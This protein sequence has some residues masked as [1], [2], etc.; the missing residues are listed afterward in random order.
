[1][2]SIDKVPPIPEDYLK[3]EFGAIRRCFVNEAYNFNIINL[4]E[5]ENAFIEWMSDPE[6]FILKGKKVF[7]VPDITTEDHDL[8]DLTKDGEFYKKTVYKFVKAAKRGNDVY[9][10]LVKEK[11]KPLKELDEVT[12][13]KDEWGVKTTNMLFI[14]LTYD[15][16]LGNVTQAWKDIGEDFHRFK[17]NLIKQYGHIEVFRTWESTN[18]YYPHIHCVILF[19]EKTFQVFKHKG[20]DGKT[21][22]RITTKDKNKIA[23]YWHSIID[24]QG[25]SDTKGA[26]GELTKYITKDLCSKKGYKT[27][28]MIWLFRKQ[29]YSVSRNFIGYIKGN[30]GTCVKIK[31]VK[32]TDLLKSDMCNLNQDVEKWEF[33]GILRGCFLGFKKEMW[34]VDVEDPPPSIKDLMEIEEKRWIAQRR[35]G[36]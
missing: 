1:V 18:H 2:G 3:N 14:T 23:N 34:V 5:V 25:C 22:Y 35:K 7:F 6:Y 15:A 10:H 24:I 27:N 9:R 17:S 29:A 26:V 8:Y 36:A 20:K 19:S 30:I 28:S 11:L 33:V 21:K 12:F 31:D 32:T 13:F 4:S 16:K